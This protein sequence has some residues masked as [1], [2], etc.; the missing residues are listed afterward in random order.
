MDMWAPLSNAQL[1]RGADVPVHSSNIGE[2]NGTHTKMQARVQDKITEGEL[3]LF[4]DGQTSEEQR[5]VGI[6][7][8]QPGPQG[9]AGADVLTSILRGL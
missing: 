4:K 8:F 7:L 1:D 9:R 2:H 6:P 3:G 5:S